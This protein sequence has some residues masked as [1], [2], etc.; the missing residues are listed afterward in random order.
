MEKKIL[1]ATV[2]LVAVLACS[3]PQGQP[4]SATKDA[5]G[6]A[7][8]GPDRSCRS[9]SDCQVASLLLDC[10]GSVRAMGLNKK[11]RESAEAVAMQVHGRAT[12]ECLAQPTVLDSGESA[13]NGEAIVVR[14]E[15]QRCVTRLAAPPSAPR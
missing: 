4:G 15:A 11:A 8:A 7:I 3:T 5:R 9:T 6:H 10:C 12:C 2:P 14:C 13:A 1:I